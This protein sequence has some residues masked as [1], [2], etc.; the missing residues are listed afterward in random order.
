MDEAYPA[1]LA[2]QSGAR[3]RCGMRSCRR[4][5]RRKT[6]LTSLLALACV[7][8]PAHAAG[9][10]RPPAPVDPQSW[11]LPADMSWKD[12]R[13]I[14]G[15][16]WA[17]DKNAPPKKLRAALILGDFS[18]RRFLV[19]QPPGSDVIGNPIGAGGVPAAKAGDF[20]KDL[21]NTPQPLNHHHTIN[22]YW[23][24]DS[25]GLVGIDMDAFGPYGL[26]RPEYQYGLNEFGEESA[27]PKDEACD[28]DFDS[29]LL[30]KS[31]P[32]VETA[33]AARGGRDYD[34]RFL[35][36]AGYDESGVWQELGE[37]RFK[38]KEDVGEAFG[39]P[40]PSKPNWAPT[41]Y[42]PWT[43]FYAARGI[44]S[45]AT[46]GVM[47][48][49]G[50]NDGASVYAHEFSHI[51]GVLDNYNNSYANPPQREYSGPWDMMSRGSFNGPGG[52]HNRWQI[53]ATLGAS[54][55]SHHM[56]RDKL[57]MGFLKPT[58]VMFLDRNLLARSGPAFADVWA[59]EIPLGDSTG[60]TG[61]H[62]LTIALT[63][64]D[65]TP[66]CTVEQDWRCDG[67]GYDNYTLEVVDRMGTDSFTPDHGVLIAKNKVAEVAPWKWVIDAHSEDIDALDFR[68][69]DGTP[70]KVTKG[71]YRQLADAL[72]HAGTGPGVV[73]EYEDKA[74]RLHFYVLGEKRDAQG[75]LSY[76]VAVRSLDGGGPAARGVK[77]AQGT[78]RPASPGR[79]AVQT[80]RVTNAGD[81]EDLIRVKASTAGD[82]PTT[83]ESDVLD[84][85]AGRTV[86][87]PVY[88]S[89]PSGAGV[90]AAEPTFPATS[91]TDA[92]KSVTRTATV[93][94]APDEVGSA[95]SRRACRSR[96]A[97]TLT[98]YRGRAHVRRARVT[99]NGRPVRTARN[100]RTARIS[101]TGRGRG[102]TRVRVR[103]RMAS[104]RVVTFTRRY[105]TCHRRA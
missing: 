17:D 5:P 98:L 1:L 15:F 61:L 85:P 30:A 75:V 70:V 73:S 67:G 3:N 46:P 64:G 27:C 11:A 26:D 57:R 20:Y 72:F 104:G 101:L 103:L 65:R 7:P 84:V 19:T 90:G 51:L 55:G 66:A 76:R 21:L 2:P 33:Q 92:S 62:G 47:A 37:M 48:T 88:V 99:V 58:E 40:D 22:E 35:L 14:P 105:A 36:H 6:I 31:A 24:E 38:N 93:T 8:A 16:D 56:L 13:P 79:V 34:F 49:E 53:P 87:V 77:V 29:E 102:V 95:T 89:G 100:R 9:L 42:V 68:R 12:Y 74:N 94:P 10:A 71:D 23:L 28:G 43:S 52:N 63:D 41:R 69:P 91:E 60:R 32:D 45:H 54:M 80:F 86:E 39:N 25:Y 18:D 83:L 78:S 4:M 96:R 59:R 50:E 82:V 97:F 81:G 44:W